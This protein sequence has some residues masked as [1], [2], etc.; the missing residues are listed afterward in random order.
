MPYKG[1]MMGEGMTYQARHK[2]W[3]WCP[4][5]VA[6]LAMGLL[7]V[8]QQMQHMIG[9]GTQWETPTYVGTSNILCLIPMRDGGAGI[10]G[11]G[12]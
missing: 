5:F 1:R 10:N 2:Q 7:A 12:V 9:L 11:R 3:V 4:G 6:D 8:H